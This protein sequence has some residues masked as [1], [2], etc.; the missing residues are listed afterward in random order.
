MRLAIAGLVSILLVSVITTATADTTDPV[1]WSQLP[2]MGPYGYDFSSESS[3][4][5]VVADDFLCSSRLPVVDLHW[6]GSYYAPGPLW[7]YP[8]SA[9]LTDPTLANDQP[10]GILQGF[11]VDFYTD[12]PGGV[13]PGMPWSHP[14]QLLYRQFVEIALV[15]EVLYG[16][17]THIGG[18]EENVWQYNVD[19][20]VPFFQDP[21]SD[22]VDVDG[23]GQDDGTVYW[24]MIQGAHFD[25][26]IQWGWHEADALWH[27]NAV[28]YWPFDGSTPPWNLVP[29][30]DMAFELTFVPEPSL[31]LLAGTGLLMLL[32][33]RRRR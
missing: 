26:A 33:R 4:F 23:D 29:N 2:N 10:P 7:P 18:I 19:L 22:P 11:F 31:F 12:V 17:V 30:K 8:N 14:G 32:V 21:L 3:L 13:D 15:T 1:K 5:S 27:D 6:W 20:P 25:P 9:S 16:T 24:L 28:Q